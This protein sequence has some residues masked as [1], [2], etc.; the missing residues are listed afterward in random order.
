M[1]KFEAMGAFWEPDTR[2]LVE[3]AGVEPDYA[4]LANWLTARGLCSNCL[5][6]RCLCH[7]S[8][9]SYSAPPAQ[10]DST[11]RKF[12]MEDRRKVRNRPR[13]GSAVPQV[14]FFEQLGE[15]GLGQVAGIF[16]VVPAA[17]GIEKLFIHP[18]LMTLLT[19]DRNAFTPYP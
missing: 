4:L 5:K 18:N 16:R 6:T 7:Q 13:V 17:A 9:P 12:F 19:A 8:S 1:A 10:E 14:P 3:V 2:G 15:E 11:A